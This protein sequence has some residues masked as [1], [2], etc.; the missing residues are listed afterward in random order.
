MSDELY[1]VLHLQDGREALTDP[2]PQDQAERTARRLAAEGVFVGSVMTVSAARDYVQDKYGTVYRGVTIPDGL[3]EDWPRSVFE[4]WKRGVDSVLDGA[5][6]TAE[7][8]DAPALY[9]V[10]YTDHDGDEQLTE[11]MAYDQ[12]QARARQ[13]KAQ[14]FTV[15]FVMGDVAAR[16]YMHARHTLPDQ[17]AE[18]PAK[19]DDWRWV[20]RLHWDSE[21]VSPAIGPFGLTEANRVSRDIRRRFRDAGLTP[22]KVTRE[23]LRAPGVLDGWVRDRIEAASRCAHC[24][25]VIEPTGGH[26]WIGPVPAPGEPQKRYHLSVDFPDCRRASGACGTEEDR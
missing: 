15:G 16:G 6:P 21:H 9:R 22:P 3:R 4:T 14:G 5:A 20:I 8:P 18:K 25:G 10:L 17:P 23:L 13:L 7:E 19:N 24:G 1:Q 2:E 12:A 26:D 11:A